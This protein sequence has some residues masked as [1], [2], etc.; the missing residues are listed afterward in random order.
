MQRRPSKR[1]VADLPV[2]VS[3]SSPIRN[4]FASGPRLTRMALAWPLR[5]TS[6]GVSQPC[7]RVPRVVASARKRGAQIGHVGEIVDR[8]ERVDMRQHGAHALRLGRE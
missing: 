7:L 5:K 3:T 4:S 1:M 2:T 8:A 6:C